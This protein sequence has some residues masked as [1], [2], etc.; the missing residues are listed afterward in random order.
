MTDAWKCPECHLDY[1]ELHP[2]IAINTIKSL[3]RRYREALADQ[4][5]EDTDALIRTRPAEGV[6]SPLEY[7]AHVADVMGPFAETIHAMN[8]QDNA[9]LTQTFW[10]PDARAVDERYN[11]KPKDA[12]LDQLQADAD[13]LVTEAEKVD[14]SGWSRTAQFAWGERD[15]LTMLQNA[16]HEGV[17]HLKDLESGIQKARNAS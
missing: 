9:D 11:D 7:A 15:M 13:R 4:P 14:A 10:D 12:V 1:G 17:H 5:D 8:T 3:P 16:A 2:P 6:W